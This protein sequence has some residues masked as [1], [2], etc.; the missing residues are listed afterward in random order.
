MFELSEDFNLDVSKLSRRR[1]LNWQ[2]PEDKIEKRSYAISWSVSFLWAKT[3]ES[4]VCFWFCWKLFVGLS[5]LYHDRR[6]SFSIFVQEQRVLYYTVC[7]KWPGGVCNVSS[8]SIREKKIAA[9][10]PSSVTNSFRTATVDVSLNCSSRG[11]YSLAIRYTRSK[12]RK[13]W[14]YTSIVIFVPV[15]TQHFVIFNQVQERN[16]IL[17]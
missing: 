3:L 17:R 7:R 14:T 6:V 4:V 10:A 8:N 11:K 15:D 2:E 12:S 1:T 5:Y 13:M 16:Y 9:V